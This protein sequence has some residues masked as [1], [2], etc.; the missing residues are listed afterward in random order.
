MKL[1]IM[2]PYL[3]P[4]IGYFQLIHVVDKFVVYDD[5]NYIKQ[6]WINRNRILNHKEPLTF[7]VPLS[8]A[9]SFAKINEVEINQKLYEGWKNKFLKTLELNYK[10][11]PFFSESAEL[12]HKVLSEQESKSISKLAVAS[13]LAL[14]NHLGIQKEFVLS[15][16]VYNNQV[17]SGK[18][19]VIDICKWENA[20]HYINPS[21]GQLLYS[22]DNFREN[23]LKLSFIKSLPVEY[24]QLKNDFVPW[25]S[26]IDV[27]MFNPIEDIQSFLNKYELI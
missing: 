5:V 23:G 12:I 20:T 22:K 24:P 13:L 16:T 21:G 10:K 18:D 7:T 9:G 2:Q 8:K 1:G 25:L 15:S 19:R 27:L 14:C 26:I 3:F 6:G 11:A 4:Y 17:L